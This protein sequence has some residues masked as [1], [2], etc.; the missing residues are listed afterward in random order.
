[1]SEDVLCVDIGGTSSKVGLLDTTGELQFVGYVPTQPE[2]EAFF[3]SLCH[4]MGTACE[5][6]SEK[7]LEICGIGVAVAG[8]LSPDR[9]QL[10]YNANLPWLELFPL[11]KRMAERFSF[12]I[13]LEVD[14][15]AACIAEARFGA[16]K[17]SSRFLCLTCGTGLG[18]GMTIDREILRFAYGC[19]GDAGH[20]I[21]QPQGPLCTCGGRGCAEVLTSVSTLA[22][23]YEE[24]AKTG[25]D[26]SLRSVIDAAKTGDHDALRILQ[27]AGEWLGIAV[28]SLANIFFP[29]RI[30]IAG[31]LSAAGTF[32]LGPAERA[33]QESASIFARQNVTFTQATL[34]PMATLMGAACPFLGHSK[35]DSHV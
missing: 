7:K 21:V 3:E 1:M 32:V 25:G 22:R 17:G 4:L 24:R 33:F 6:A 15:N 18:V 5:V 8:F 9:D 26:V 29:D 19:M 12:P 13:E 23:N 27:E 35:E 31:G 14:S 30:A 16:G 11:K 34:G 20:V 2:A 10:A 28:A